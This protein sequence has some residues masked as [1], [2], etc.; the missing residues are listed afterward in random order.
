MSKLSLVFLGSKPIG[1]HCLHY[2]LQQGDSLGVEVKAILSNDN[3]VFSKSLSLTALATAHQIPVLSSLD[4][5]PEVDFLYSVQY[6][7]IL[8]QTQ[9]RCARKIAVNLHMAPL[10]EYRGC[11]QFSFAIADQKKSFGTTI[12]RID[13]RIDHG[14]ILFEKRFD[15][16]DHCWVDT[17]YQLTFDASLDLFIETLPDLLQGRYTPLSQTE[18][19][20]THGTSLHYRKDIESLKNIHLDWTAEQIE[21]HIRATYM[22]GFEPPYTLIDGEKI[23]FSKSWQ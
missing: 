16:P 19:V 18:R 20:A 1:Y 14:D 10:P 8:T 12:H 9:I 5:L 23:Y 17:L 3:P 21:R 4:E 11:N 15:I 2:L 6:H 13:E 7:Q 22:P